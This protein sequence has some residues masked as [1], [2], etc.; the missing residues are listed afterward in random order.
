MS[1]RYDPTT[2]ALNLSNM[3]NNDELRNQGVHLSIGRPEIGFEVLRIIGEF[4]PEV[5]MLTS[6][7]SINHVLWDLYHVSGK[8][9]WYYATHF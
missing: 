2:K 6:C 4:I 5:R 8:L 9:L 1:N 7:E 3:Y